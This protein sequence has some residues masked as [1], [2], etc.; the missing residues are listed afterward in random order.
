M[1]GSSV[2]PKEIK[3]TRH[4]KKSKNEQQ[5]LT[6]DSIYSSQ[7]VQL[8]KNFESILQSVMFEIHQIKQQQIDSTAE[9]NLKLNSISSKQ[10][11]MQNSVTVVSNDLTSSIDKCYLNIKDLEEV[12]M[13]EINLEKTNVLPD[14]SSLQK[15]VEASHDTLRN[16]IQSM[17]NSV[18]SLKRGVEKMSKDRKED[19]NAIVSTNAQFQELMTEI[20]RDV[21]SS[22]EIITEMEKLTVLAQLEEFQKPA[23]TSK[24]TVPADVNTSTSTSN[25]YAGL[26]E[27]VD[28]EIT[29]RTDASNEPNVIVIAD[30]SV[31]KGQLNEKANKQPERKPSQNMNSSVQND[32]EKKDETSGRKQ[33]SNKNMSLT[34]DTVE[35]GIRR[36]GTKRDKVYIIGDS[37]AGQINQVEMGKSTRTFVQKLRAPKIQDV[38]KVKSQVK[39][40]KV[41]VV[42]TGINNIRASEST[43]SMVTEL[44]E[45]VKSLKEEAP[46][47]TVV[48]SKA[49]PVGDKKLDIERNLFNANIMKELENY[50][51]K[52]NSLDHSNLA[53]HAFPIRVST[54]RT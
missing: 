20:N 54:D 37:I 49:I 9:I 16:S 10:H 2:T 40:A 52:V 38:S 53:E 42:H 46:D 28:E 39:D 36:T 26:S 23:K 4:S 22:K 13:T 34:R 31:D 11:D 6:E 8:M 44:V 41:I 19:L 18:S 30:E 32:G 24:P 3:N 25:M 12:R 48:V 1:N 15:K 45:A 7:T 33:D 51:V 47:S 43:D 50:E 17:E 5:K 27:D 21:K 14:I 29:F 35:V